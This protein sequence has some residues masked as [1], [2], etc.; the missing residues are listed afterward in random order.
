MDQPAADPGPNFISMPMA[1]LP[2]TDV[3]MIKRTRALQEERD[4]IGTTQHMYSTK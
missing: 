2:L 4:Q 1:I 3:A